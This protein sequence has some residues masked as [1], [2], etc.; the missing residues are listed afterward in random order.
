MLRPIAYLLGRGSWLVALSLT[1]GSPV[2]AES[3]AAAVGAEGSASREV[4]A[5][6][7]RFREASVA[8][9]NGEWELA[10]GLYRSAYAM[11]PHATTLYNI[12]YCHG[13]LGQSARALYYATRALDP[14][15]F[16]AGRRLAAERQAEAQAFQKQLLERASVVTVSVDPARAFTLRVDGA[17]LV[18]TG[19]PDGS[20]VPDPEWSPAADPVFTER[21]SLRLD[22]GSH[23]F[24]VTSGGRPFVRSL[25]VVAGQ[26]VSMP[27]SLQPDA[28]PKSPRAHEAAAPVPPARAVPSA[29]TAPAAREPAGESSVYRPLAIGSFVAGGTGLSLALVSGIVALTTHDQLEEECPDGECDEA[30]SQA[31]DRYQTAAQLTNVGLWTGLLGGAL[32]VGFVL[33]E[34]THEQ[35]QLSVVVAPARVELRGAF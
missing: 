19:T 24:V 17:R 7:Q 5:A 32:G 20:F 4:D 11:Y 18:L 2:F 29:A 8:A 35:Q 30:E 12:A 26:V 14:A 28:V 3:G 10:L 13:Q 25:D 21:V 22:P 15:A 23:E 1:L 6:R 16:E 9:E 33:L 27:W 34:R 31:V